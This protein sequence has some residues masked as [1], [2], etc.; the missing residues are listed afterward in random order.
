M[1]GKLSLAAIP[2][3]SWITLGAFLGMLIGFLFLLILVT[4]LGKWQYLWKE[5]FT[6]VDHKKIGIMY[7]IVAIVMGLRGFIDSLMLRTQQTFSFGTAHGYLSAEHFNQIFTGHGVIMIFFMAMLFLI[8]LINIAVPLQIG[9]RDVAFPV[10]NSISLWLLISAAILMNISLG[11]G[12]FAET[13]WNAYPPLSELQFSPSVGVDYY[14]WILEIGGISSLL[15]GINFLV[16]II[17]LRAPGMTLMKMPLF[18]WTTLATNILIIGAFP[19]LTVLLALLGLDRYLGMH[20][21]TNSGGGNMMLYVNWFWAWGH[22]EV[23]ILILPAFGIFSEVVA[24]FMHK[25]LFGYTSMV[26]SIVAITI[27]SYLVWLH[28]FFVMGNGGTVNAIFGIMTML[29]AIPTGVKIF[30]WVFTIH[31]GRLHLTSPMLWT[32]GFLITFVLGG[33]SGVM[34]AMA[35]ADFVLHN[36]EFL[37][38]HFHNV[39]ISGTV[40]GAI[41]GYIYWFPKACGFTLNEK[42]GKI[43]FVFFFTGVVITFTPL[44]ELGFMGMTRRLLHY[45]NP[46]WQMPIWIAQI[47][48]LIIGLGVFLLF[49]QLFV[50]FLQR[51]QNIDLTG[52]PW[53]GRTME[54]SIASPPPH[55]NFALIPTINHRDEFWVRKQTGYAHQNSNNYHDI[56]MPKNSSVGLFIGLFSLIFGFA[57][58]WH[59][60]WLVVLSML[61]IML[62][63]MIP[64]FN[65]GL[66]YYIPADEVEEIE[67]HHLRNSET[68]YVK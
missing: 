12:E 4:Y 42:L 47:G 53:N 11:I 27:L 25:K 24:N 61:A 13:G 22:P 2:F 40:F 49:L 9:T 19:I 30:N 63:I 1:L 57:M 39:I 33:M 38:A 68:H 3:G 36:S 31:R 21:F 43:A 6:S 52:D 45:D 34:L 10:M 18:A 62:T 51:K 54:W 29:I 26:Y 48:V 23:Y 37:I 5:W 59:I 56:L 46:A 7:I 65:D 64:G 32:L 44:Y 20:F 16:T 50:S 17:Q 15:T 41:A 28:H 35:P 66:Y 55:Y 60:W 14:I 67:E 58:V 8:G